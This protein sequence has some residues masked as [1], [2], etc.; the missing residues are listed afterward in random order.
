MTYESCSD[1]NNILVSLAYVIAL[2]LPNLNTPFQENQELRGIENATSLDFLT[3]ECK[4]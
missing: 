1:S 3:C 4:G 2:H